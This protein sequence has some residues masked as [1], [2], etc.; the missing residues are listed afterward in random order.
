MSIVASARMLTTRRSERLDRRRERRYG[1]AARTSS[2][3][4]LVVLGRHEAIVAAPNA[5]FRCVAA[6]CGELIDA[7]RLPAQ[8]QQRAEQ[9]PSAA[10]ATSIDAAPSRGS[11]GGRA[12]RDRAGRGRA[13]RASASPAARGA[14]RRCGRAE[15]RRPRELKARCVVGEVGLTE[16]RRRAVDVAERR[17]RLGETARRG[18]NRRRRRT[19]ARGRARAATRPRCARRAAASTSPT[20]RACVA[21]PQWVWWPSGASS[22]TRRAR[23]SQTLFVLAVR[24]GGRSN[25]VMTKPARPPRAAAARTRAQTRSSSGRSTWQ[26]TTA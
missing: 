25:G 26:E 13:C 24:S 19:A 17:E 11:A 22:A 12:R 2:T 10:R 9:R 23:S 15:P 7:Q 8:A 6:R 4:P 3:R 18:T 16:R 21:P 5:T 1:I 14:R 20:G